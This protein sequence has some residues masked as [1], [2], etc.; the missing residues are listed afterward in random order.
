M[1]THARHSADPLSRIFFRQ[2]YLVLPGLLLAILIATVSLFWPVL[3][4]FVLKMSLANGWLHICAFSVLCAIGVYRL[5]QSPGLPLQTPRFAFWPALIWVSCGLAY[6]LNE[7]QVG[8]NT[9]SAALFILFVYGLSGFCLPQTLWRSLFIPTSLLILVLPFEHYLDIYL[10][11]PLRLLSAEW[12]SSV[13]QHAGLPLLTVESILTI[14]NRAAI[15]DLDCSGIKSLWI[16]LIFYLLLTWIERYR[17]GWCWLV[18]GLLYVFLL[19]LANVARIT[20][21]VLLELVLEK[22]GIAESL[23]QGLGLLG[24]T[25]ASAVI[26]WVSRV[27]VVMQKPDAFKYPH[28]KPS[29]GRGG[30]VKGKD[31]PLPNPPL[32]RGEHP[33]VPF[34]RKNKPEIAIYLVKFLCLHYLVTR[35]KLPPLIRGGL[36]RGLRQICHYEKLC[37]HLCLGRTGDGN[38]TLT[39][40]LIVIITLNLL[41]QPQATTTQPTTINPLTLPEQY[42]LTA[43]ALNPQEASFFSSNRS[44]ANKYKLTLTLAGKPVKVA[45]VL[46]WSRAW[47]THHVPENCYLSQGFSINAQGVWQLPDHALRYLQL[48]PPHQGVSTGAAQTA[49]YWFQSADSSTPDYSARVMDNLF[50]PGRHWV[51]V[52]LLFEQ[53]VAPHQITTFIQTLKHAS[54]DQFHDIQ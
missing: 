53:P 50:H 32:I 45:M 48:N 7:S 2:Q 42:Q 25:V 38:G 39:L 46:V 54:G 34:S 27:L 22:P 28:S 33:V 9:L 26:W 3:Q 36:G 4:W 11:F 16:G 51:M 17:I 41:Y 21:L 24:F 15:V 13:L 43:T 29:S 8:F 18:I 47:K 12:S 30:I 6:L 23:H 20:V 40:L 5:Y 31:K 14:D 1:K 19:V 49:L 35:V 37:R 10:G 44:Q 52:S